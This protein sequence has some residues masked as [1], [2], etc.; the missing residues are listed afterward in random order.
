MWFLIFSIQKKVWS[1]KL[2]PWLHDLLPRKKIHVHKDVKQLFRFEWLSNY[3]LQ[4][5]FNYHFKVDEDVVK[6]SVGMQ[7]IDVF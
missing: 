1:Q 6:T 5:F 2:N 7:A 3:V 4:E